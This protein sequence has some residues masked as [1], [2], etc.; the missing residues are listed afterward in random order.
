MLGFLKPKSEP[1]KVIPIIYKRPIEDLPPA[2]PKINP[3]WVDAPYQCWFAGKPFPKNAGETV[4][5]IGASLDQED[6]PFPI[7][8]TSETPR[9]H[10][11]DGE[12]QEVPK[13]IKEDPDGQND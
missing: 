7:K 5:V 1:A 12:L 2:Y 11:K 10:Y 8:V 13:F 9:F 6:Q 3:D 4:R